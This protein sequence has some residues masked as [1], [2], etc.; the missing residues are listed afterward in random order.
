MRSLNLTA[1]PGDCASKGRADPHSAVYQSEA[2]KRPRTADV[3]VK[4]RGERGGRSFDGRLQ[5]RARRGKS[6]SALPRLMAALVLSSS[7]LSSSMS[8]NCRTDGA[9]G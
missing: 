1:P 7:A 6:A 4:Q 5:P 8:S 2:S 3:P 9:K